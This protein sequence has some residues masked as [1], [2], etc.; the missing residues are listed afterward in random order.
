VFQHRIMPFSGAMGSSP[1]SASTGSWFCGSANASWRVE[2][3]RVCWK[4]PKARSS[5]VLDSGTSEVGQPVHPLGKAALDVIPVEAD[6]RVPMLEQRTEPTVVGAIA[7]TSE[8]G[9]R[10][11]RRVARAPRLDRCLAA[12]AG[13]DELAPSEAHGRRTQG[14]EPRP[15]RRSRRGR[16]PAPQTSVGRQRE[17]SEPSPRVSR[18]DGRPVDRRAQER[19]ACPVRVRPGLAWHGQPD[20]CPRT[21]SGPWLTRGPRGS[22]RRIGQ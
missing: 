11:G 15:A 13:A 4:S 5:R 6:R 21:T 18:V 7:S 3:R 9:Q 8:R 17:W 12:T 10:L 1:K 16:E 19:G 20:L 14:R 22:R 2:S